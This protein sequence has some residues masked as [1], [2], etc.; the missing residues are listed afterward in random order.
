MTFVISG[1][2]SQIMKKPDY[3]FMIIFLLFYSCVSGQKD[4]ST[5]ENKDLTQ[6]AVVELDYL[7]QLEQELIGVWVNSSMKVWVNSYN[8]SDTSFFVDIDEDTWEMKMSIKPIVTT[9]R[10]DGTYSS[11]FRNSLDAVTYKPEGTWM[12]DGDS[13]IMEDHQAIYKYQVFIDGDV[14][15]FKSLI[16]WDHDGKA[17]DEYAGEQRKSKE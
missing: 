12:L 2:L 9:I 10:D 13:L 6:E 11:E 4:I 5:I 8:N 7:T 15:E 14:A 17:D 3:L 1:R 16:D